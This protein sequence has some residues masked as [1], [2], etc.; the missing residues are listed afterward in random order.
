MKN[1]K[2][3][4]TLYAIAIV[5]INNSA[6]AQS[7]EFGDDVIDN[8]TPEPPVAP[9]DNYIAVVISFCLL[10]AFI[11]MFKKERKVNLCN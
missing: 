7:I 8:T 4:K 2:I 3:K 1:T 6:F 10:Y 5:L 9:I 11:I